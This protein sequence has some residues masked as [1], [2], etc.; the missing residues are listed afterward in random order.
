MTFA[1]YYNEKNKDNSH[2]FLTAH[3]I[4]EMPSDVYADFIS[5]LSKNDGTIGV[6]IYH[7]HG[8]NPETREIEFQGMEI[9][10][11]LRSWQWMRHAPI[12]DWFWKHRAVNGNK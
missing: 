9:G 12:Y 1:E 2:N 10:Y 8:M 11:Y 5:H 7:S 4:K 3:E 6:Y